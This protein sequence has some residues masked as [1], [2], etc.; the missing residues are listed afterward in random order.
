M[1]AQRGVEQ[2]ALELSRFLRDGEGT[3]RMPSDD[4]LPRLPDSLLTPDVDLDAAMARRPDVA[5]LLDQKRAA[6]VELRFQQNQLLP[7]LDV[8]IAVSGDL[9]TRSAEDVR[10]LLHWHVLSARAS[11]L[12][13][14]WRGLEEEFSL[15]R[16]GLWSCSRAVAAQHHRERRRPRQEAAGRGDDRPRR[17]QASAAPRRWRRGQAQAVCPASR[18]R[19]AGD[20]VR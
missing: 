4:E 18:V 16:L 5:R 10:V 19:P 9:G 7:S 13:Q 1:Q 14:P 8:G 15:K 17:R 12:G 3:P 6:E 2:A 20:T 11:A